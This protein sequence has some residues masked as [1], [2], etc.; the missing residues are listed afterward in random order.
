VRIT[1]AWLPTQSVNHSTDRAF[2]GAQNG[3]IEHR[4]FGDVMPRTV[5]QVN[6]IMAPR[7]T[8]EDAFNATEYIAS[9]QGE[10]TSS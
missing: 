5:V 9:L 3:I 6:E 1:A 4:M 2:Q 7:A 10:Q 8:T